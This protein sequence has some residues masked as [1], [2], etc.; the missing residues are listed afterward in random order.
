MVII[1]RYMFLSSGLTR[2]YIVKTKKA[3]VTRL[4]SVYVLVVLHRLAGFNAINLAAEKSTL[5]EPL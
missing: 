1:K 4:L 5:S 2:T 3:V